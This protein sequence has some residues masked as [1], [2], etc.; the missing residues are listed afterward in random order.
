[1]EKTADK[2]PILPQALQK[3]DTL[4]L[5]CP[6][7]PLTDSNTFAEGIHILE[8]AGYRV[9]YTEAVNAR[10][11]YLA[12]PDDLRAAEFNRMWQDE[13]VKAILAVRGGYGCLR[14]VE[15]LDLEQV[16]TNPKLLIGFSDITI[17][18]NHIAARTGLVT[19]HGPMLTTLNRSNAESR[20]SLLNAFSRLPEA[21]TSKDITV[22]SDHDARGRLVGGNLANLVHLL[23]TPYE[24]DWRDAIVFLEDIGE[25]PYKVDRM[26]TQLAATGK[27]QQARGII[28]GSFSEAEFDDPAESE[29]IHGRLRELAGGDT[30]LWVNFPVGHGPRNLCLPIGMTAEMDSAAGTLHFIND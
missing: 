5:V 21:V 19:L 8:E 26:L 25:P 10:R 18:L 3:G 27:L 20:S 13:Q 14:I 11:N 9:K 7:G 30:A 16:R 23:G 12:G 17:L 29:L 24:I 2:R 28:I 6:A 15:F 22:L 1:M 4:G